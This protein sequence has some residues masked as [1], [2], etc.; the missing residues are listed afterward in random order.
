MIEDSCRK[1]GIVLEAF[2]S[3]IEKNK[4]K[5]WT[6]I[7]EDVCQIGFRLLQHPYKQTGPHLLAMDIFMKKS[8]KPFEYSPSVWLWAYPEA[9][10]R[11][12]QYLQGDD[13]PENGNSGKK[14]TCTRSCAHRN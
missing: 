8:K 2:S 6:K 4:M 12:R 11:Y 3:N 9:G 10:Y 14:D 13:S 5:V 7:F 1:R